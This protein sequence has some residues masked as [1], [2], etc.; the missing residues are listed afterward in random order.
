MVL[1]RS[2]K[3]IG[4]YQSKTM[5]LTRAI[6]K[7]ILFLIFA[8]IYSNA[9]Y[10]SRVPTFGN[11]SD[12]VLSYDGSSYVIPIYDSLISESL[13]IFGQFE[14][15]SI[16]LI[17]SLLDKT[18]DHIILD[19]GS[20][21][22]VWT[23]PLAKFAEPNG[24]VYAFDAQK[25]MVLYLSST[26][27]LNGIANVFPYNSIVTNV[28]GY[29]PLYQMNYQKRGNYGAYSI[30]HLKTV[31]E[32]PIPHY[33]PHTLLDMFYQY[34]LSGKCPTFIKFDIELHE[35]FA[36][37]GGFNM[38]LEC[39]PILYIEATCRHLLKSLVITL[40][41]LGYYV[42]WVVLPFLDL[43]YTH[44]GRR[45]NMEPSES[46]VKAVIGGM[47]VLAYKKSEKN[48]A[49]FHIPGVLYPIQVNG[50][51]GLFVVED[52][53]IEVCVN[54]VCDVLRHENEG[55]FICSNEHVSDFARD[56]WKRLRPE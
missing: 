16:D 1:R 33:V 25:S 45:P 32:D 39:H 44:N 26:L 36:I 37:I 38:L 49:A 40:D 55:D 7:I 48:K 12:V 11:Y 5:L 28:S 52:Y 46:L 14:K 2:L 34:E 41:T 17:L 4:R 13:R 54:T 56:Y 30:T 35:I 8:D 43:D 21:V 27:V 19:I 23:I 51:E 9:N 50:T 6:T 42:S 31:A 29:S 20:N 15:P 18:N 3:K 53:K 24:K 10:A 22:G 47:N